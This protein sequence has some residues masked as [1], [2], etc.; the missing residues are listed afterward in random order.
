MRVWA[1]LAGGSVTV[2][3]LPGAGVAVTVQVPLA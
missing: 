1:D 2:A 3:T